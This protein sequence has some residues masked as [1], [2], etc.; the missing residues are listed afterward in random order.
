MGVG[1]VTLGVT[2]HRFLRDLPRLREAVELA[3]DALQAHFPGRPLRLLSA[4]AEGADQLVAR[5]VLERAGELV[6]RLPLGAD[7]YA[8]AFTSQASR[9]EFRWLLGQ[10][11]SVQIMA[12]AAGPEEAYAL[13]G[14]WVADHAQALVTLWD[15]QPPQGPGGTGEVVARALRRG[16]PVYHILAGNRHPGTREG[17]TL[18]PDQGRLVIHPG[19]RYGR[20]S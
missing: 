11:T 18:G 12:P 6:V 4:L 15:G 14:H 17:T 2:G 9:D 13:V 3:L 7:Q 8:L 19:T 16:I 1:P 20:T 5:A 10:A